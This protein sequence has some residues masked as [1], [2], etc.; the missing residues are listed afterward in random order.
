MTALLCGGVTGAGTRFDRGTRL[1][2]TY[3]SAFQKPEQ[4]WKGELGTLFGIKVMRTTNACYQTSG[5]TRRVVPGGGVI[6]ALVF[7]K[8]ALPYP[9]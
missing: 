6:A 3:A 4:V 1:S 7:G 5:G 9:A 8:D 2:R